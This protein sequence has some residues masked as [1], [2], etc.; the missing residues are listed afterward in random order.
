MT[1]VDIITNY[2]QDLLTSVKYAEKWY[3][4]M[5]KKNCYNLMYTHFLYNYFITNLQNT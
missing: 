1:D 5:I 3:L 2:V 4:Y